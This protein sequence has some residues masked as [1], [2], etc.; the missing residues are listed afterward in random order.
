MPSLRQ[1][2]N[3]DKPK[4]LYGGGCDAPTKPMVDRQG[5]DTRYSRAQAFD[6][7]K[8]PHPQT[9][10]RQKLCAQEEKVAIQERNSRV[11]LMAASLLERI[12]AYESGQPMPRLSRYDAVDELFDLLLSGEA[13][14]P[15]DGVTVRSPQGNTT[16][17]MDCQTRRGLKQ[18]A[19]A[20]ASP[21]GGDHF[22]QQQ[23]PAEQQASVSSADLDFNRTTVVG[24]QDV[25]GYA[26]GSNMEPCNADISGSEQT[27]VNADQPVYLAADNS[28]EALALN[29]IEEQKALDWRAT[30]LAWLGTLEGVEYLQSKVRH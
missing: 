28:P 18:L 15:E 25:T 3:A 4:T 20:D 22:E 14:A 5:T 29:S 10:S 21:A 2:D 9:R 26:A 12:D 27:Q 8:T 30:M 19:T 24:V 6:Q 1:P 13:S 23:L 7:H 17:A 16:E 11:I